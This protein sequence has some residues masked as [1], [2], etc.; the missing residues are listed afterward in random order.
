MLLESIVS[1]DPSGLEE[2]AAAKGKVNNHPTTESHV[3]QIVPRNP[4][5][6]TINRSMFCRLWPPPLQ[7]HLLAT[8]PKIGSRPTTTD[9]S[10]KV[11]KMGGWWWCGGRGAPE[12]NARRITRPGSDGDYGSSPRPIGHKLLAAE[13]DQHVDAGEVED[14]CPVLQHPVAGILVNELILKVEHERIIRSDFHFR[15]LPALLI[16]TLFN[17]AALLA[18]R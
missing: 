5:R 8:L 13:D 7:N 2:E 10:M 16:H 17:P 14:P 9:L 18:K 6:V 12:L 11:Y 15:R 4:T 3:E 1:S